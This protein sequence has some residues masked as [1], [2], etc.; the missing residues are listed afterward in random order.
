MAVGHR[1]PPAGAPMAT[2]KQDPAMAALEPSRLRSD[3]WAGLKQGVLLAAAALVLTLPPGR[4]LPPQSPATH[5]HAPAPHIFRS[6]DFVARPASA[7]WASAAAALAPCSEARAAERAARAP[8]TRSSPSSTISVCPARTR[9]PG[10]TSTL[11][12]GARMRAAMVAVARACTTP[13]ESIALATS[14]IAT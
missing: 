6:A 11:R 13:P 4:T 10:D 2:R 9:S 12:T 3:L 5:S 7:D 8:A 1:P 14:A